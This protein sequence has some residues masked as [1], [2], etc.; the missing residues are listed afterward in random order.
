LYGSHEWVNPS[1]SNDMA[2]TAA[3]VM[4]SS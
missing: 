3:N 2:L 4:V 1:I